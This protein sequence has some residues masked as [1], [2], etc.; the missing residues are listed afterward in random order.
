M[1][2]MDTYKQMLIQQKE[3]DRRLKEAGGE[4]NNEIGRRDRRDNYQNSGS[5]RGSYA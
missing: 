5:N 4:V 3:M 1:D 2:T